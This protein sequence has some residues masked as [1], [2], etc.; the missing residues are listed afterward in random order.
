MAQA[1]QLRPRCWARRERE[2]FKVKTSS[3][4][5]PSLEVLTGRAGESSVRTREHRRQVWA[6]KT[7]GGEGGAST[8]V[9]E[10]AD[11]DAMGWGVWERGEAA[12]SWEHLAS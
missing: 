7:D 5:R 8:F 11:M 4:G 10:A 6:T 9:V 1:T 3:S 12:K 2:R